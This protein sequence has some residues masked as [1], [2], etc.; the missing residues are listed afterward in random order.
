MD[1]NINENAGYCL[2]CSAKPCKNKGCPLSNN[3]PDFI[4][5]VK[6]NKIKDAY[7][8]LIE[9]TM[10]GSICGRICPHEKQCEGS[11]I[12]GIK[13]SSVQIGKLESYV[14]DEALKNEYYK[15]IEK[16]DSLKGKNIAIIGSGPAGL[17]ASFFLLKKGAT[18]TIFEKYNEIGGILAH[19][20]P[21]FRL[22]KDILNST[23]EQIKYLGINIE[24]GK[25]LG[26]NISLKDLKKDYD[27]IF[28]AI[29]A[30]IPTQM[31]I[32]GE[33]LKGVY[34]G[35]SVLENNN[36]PDYKNKTVAVIG[37]RKCCNGC[38]KNSKVKRC[39]K[40]ICNI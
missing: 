23:I 36:H 16:D 1:K 11:C 30:N 29:G 7:N 14:F 40:S 21:D 19:G 10:L 37:G 32:E 38:C 31:N 15:E 17:N 20:I 39:K 12:R 22:K 33:D 5:L 25:E 2:N 4:K 8:V 27:A 24:Y 34:G 3:I 13:G 9:N 26:K 35:N 6:E 28:L 18:V